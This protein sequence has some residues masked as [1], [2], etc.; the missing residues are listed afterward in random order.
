MAIY[1]SIGLLNDLQVNNKAIIQAV[2]TEFIPLSW[3]QLNQRPEAGRWS[4]LECLEHINITLRLYFPRI[5]AAI[6]KAERKGWKTTEHFKSGFI[7]HMFAT[8][9]RPLPDGSIESKTSTFKFFDPPKTSPAQ[10]HTIPEFIE[11]H[12]KLIELMERSKSIDLAKPK[13]KSAI[14]PIIMFKLGDIYN[15]LTA[16][17]QRHLQQARNV[18]QSEAFQSISST[19]I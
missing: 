9:M 17:T 1:R 11:S 2:E 16:H 13:A 8:K 7:G 10:E 14:G 3:E 19:K 4:I 15:F 6:E 5:E 18:M 12:Q